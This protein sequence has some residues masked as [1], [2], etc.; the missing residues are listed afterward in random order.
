[1]HYKYETTLI[2][3]S[4][5]ASGRVFYSLPGHPAFP[6]RLASE[7]FQRCLAHRESIYAA[8]APCTLY[9]PCCGAAYHL[10][11]LG[12][13]HGKH[14]REIIA[15]DIDENAIDLAD[16]NLGLLSE[17]G[18][19]KRLHEIT[20]MIEHYDKESHKDALKSAEILKDKITFLNREHAITTRVF[21]ANVTDEETISRNIRA[22]SV[23]IIFT[24]VPYGLHSRWER[25]GESPNPIGSMLNALTEIVSSSS[26]LAIASDKRQKVSHE[27]YQ[28]IEQ[29]QVGKRRVTILRP[30]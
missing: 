4:D 3:Y 20:T 26:I 7:I 11:I 30:T 14:I 23:D 1:M 19:E 6:V 16:R 15:S 28:R 22:R 24:D 9:D 17:A 18:L 8:L 12:Y 10:S 29:F 25:M 2:D 5:L 21:Q 13:L 27:R